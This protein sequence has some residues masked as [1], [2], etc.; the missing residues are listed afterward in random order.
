MAVEFDNNI[1]TTRKTIF[2]DI[3]GT[4]VEFP[5]SNLE[6]IVNENHNMIALPGTVQ[7]LWE[8]E[9]KGYNIILTTGRKESMRDATEKQL[10]RAGIFWDQLIMGLGPG[11]RVLINDMVPIVHQHRLGIIEHKENAQ[12]INLKRDEGISEVDV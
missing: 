1:E 2:C 8:W 7:K 11:K 6:V 3:D 4:L 9:S 5:H 12:V 10:R